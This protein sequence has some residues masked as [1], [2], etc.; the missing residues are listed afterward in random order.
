MKRILLA[1]YGNIAKAFEKILREQEPEGSFSLGVCE[2]TDGNDIMKFLPQHI[3]D[4]DLIINTSLADS[5][6]LSKMCIDYGMDYIDAGV[7]E[8]PEQIDSTPS[9]FM[10]LIKEMT[11]WG[12]HSHVMLG[13][14]IN[15]GILEHIY[16]KHKP[17]GKHYAFELE[18]DDSV[19]FQHELFCTWSPFMYAEEAV[20]TEKVVVTPQ[21][22]Q[23]VDEQLNTDGGTM[24]LNYHCGQRH[25]LPMFHEELL[26]MQLS[27]PDLLG[28]A[29]LY[30]APVNIQNFFL[31]NRANLSNDQ[32]LSIPVPQDLQGEDHVGMLFWDTKERLYWVKNVTANQTTWQRYGIN[33]VCWQTG[34]GVWI[35][36]RLLDF[37]N[38]DHPHTMTELSQLMPDAI[39]GLLQ[40]V[41]F[42]LEIE[43]LPFSVEEFKKNI[44]RYF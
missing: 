9:E 8:G 17:R 4:Y 20:Y 25:Y 43:E 39:D 3:N 10:S 28:V 5:I 16:Q 11:T 14:G 6:E 21:G 33:A 19:S 13:F 24:T 18:H 26:S 30:Q 27:C 35:A 15:P 32:I 44:M 2:L 42:T 29:Y 12:T 7:V 34:V 22:F 23:I 41:G 36:Y 40:Q 31:S 1:G 38:T 37:V